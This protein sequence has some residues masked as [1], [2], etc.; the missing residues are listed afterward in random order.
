MNEVNDMKFKFF[1]WNAIPSPK[2]VLKRFYQ[3]TA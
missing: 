3:I 2:S 1:R